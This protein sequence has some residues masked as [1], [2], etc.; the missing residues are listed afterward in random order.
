M[1][2]LQTGVRINRLRLG[3]G[4]LVVRGMAKC[5]IRNSQESMMARLT[6]TMTAVTILCV[7]LALPTAAQSPTAQRIGSS[8]KEQLVGSWSLVQNC[9]EFQDGK[10]NCN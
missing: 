1:S 6:F 2:L 7:V 9:E 4:I 3:V 5:I 10:K 8:L